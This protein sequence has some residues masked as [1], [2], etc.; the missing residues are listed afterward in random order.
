M[1]RDHLVPA[2]KEIFPK[3]P[4]CGKWVIALKVF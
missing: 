4:R 3:A 2:V 1:I